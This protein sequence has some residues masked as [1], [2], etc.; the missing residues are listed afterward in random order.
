MEEGCV[1]RV[2]AFVPCQLRT[3]NPA[4]PQDTMARP[5]R[6][7]IGDGL[8]DS[9]GKRGEGVSGSNRVTSQVAASTR[10]RACLV[11]ES[12]LLCRLS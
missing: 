2:A 11:Y 4:S 3:H 7:R 9:A 8:W 6:L 12:T 5:L 1:G 10:A